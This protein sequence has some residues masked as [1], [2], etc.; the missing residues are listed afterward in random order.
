[1]THEKPLWVGN[2]GPEFDR[3]IW[4][5]GKFIIERIPERPNNWEIR[6]RGNVLGTFDLLSR[7]P[8]K[9]TFE[10]YKKAVI[11]NFVMEKTQRL[12]THLEGFY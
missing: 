10:R 7:Q 3:Y 9:Y 5:Q 4:N 12:M 1:M 6:Y 11:S 8:R 2:V